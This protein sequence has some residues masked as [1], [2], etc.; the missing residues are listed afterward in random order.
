MNW[1]PKMHDSLPLV[2]TRFAEISQHKSQQVPA[3]GG[4]DSGPGL[5]RGKKEIRQDKSL[6]NP[7]QVTCGVRAPVYR[8]GEGDIDTHGIVV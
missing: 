2:L 6:I 7:L 4:Y 5:A 1:L 3:D 8:E